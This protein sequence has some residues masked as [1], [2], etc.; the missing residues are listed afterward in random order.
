M[1]R[2]SDG[3]VRFRVSFFDDQ[4]PVS[5]AEGYLKVRPEVLERPSSTTWSVTA[6]AG[7]SVAAQSDRK[8]PENGESR[9][10]TLADPYTGKTVDFFNGSARLE[11]T[12]TLRERARARVV[13]QFKN[14]ALGG[15]D[16]TRTFSVPLY[17]IDVFGLNGL[18]GRFG[19][20]T[21]LN[22]S[23]GIAINASG[24]GFQYNWHN[25]MIGH[26]VNSE[27]GQ[28]VPDEANQDNS[29]SL[30]RVS[31]APGFSIFKHVDL[32]GVYGEKKKK[33]DTPYDYYTWGGQL[34]FASSPEEPQPKSTFS[35]LSGSVSY[36]HSSRDVGKQG[37]TPRTN[38]SGNVWLLDTGIT[39]L[40]EGGTDTKALRSLSFL[41]GAGTGDDPNSP[42]RDESYLGETASFS[43]FDS[44]F[45][46]SFPS[47][48]QDGSPARLPF[49]IGLANKFYL[50]ASYVE[51]DFKQINFL[52]WIAQLFQVAGDAK[53]PATTLK[54]HWFH[55]DEP[56]QGR[57]DAGF[58]AGL[59][60][61]IEVPAG[62][63]HSLGCSRYFPGNATRRFFLVEPMQCS[64]Q[65][66]LTL[67]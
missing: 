19:K 9:P 52:W 29:V 40:H 8:R 14:G 7:Y 60:W 63:K 3:V 21:M 2:S 57:R 11:L 20:Y 16:K 17:T 26:I 54:A 4:I 65:V 58:E 13:P 51:R 28:G 22:P 62:V 27:S 37:T 15:E 39:W 24:E 53:S 44:M 34:F 12:Q 31:G 1:V 42:H 47:V 48:L 41:L 36:F 33:Q 49:G 55:L 46:G 61:Q 64:L 56:F 35:S 18:S 38:G 43:G 45:L 6:G 10:F 23:R 32:F 67:Q 59:Q 5:N 30:L 25:I 50:G 66:S